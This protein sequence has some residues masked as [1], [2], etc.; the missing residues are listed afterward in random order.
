MTEPQRIVSLS[1]FYCGCG[2]QATY[3]SQVGPIFDAGAV[4][5]HYTFG[6]RQHPTGFTAPPPADSAAPE[7]PSS[8]VAKL[9]GMATCYYGCHCAL[10]NWQS[11]KHCDDCKD[12]QFHAAVR[13]LAISAKHLI[14]SKYSSGDDDAPIVNT[15]ALEGL[16]RALILIQPLLETDSAAPAKPSSVDEP[17]R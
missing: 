17:D 5:M 1:V 15:A 7:K 2:Q 12:R 10:C 13:E 4:T 14:E 3:C 11:D 6:C 9:E 16:Q 8:V